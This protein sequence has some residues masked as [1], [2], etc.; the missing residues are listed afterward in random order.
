MSQTTTSDYSEQVN[1]VLRIRDI[2]FGAQMR[3]YEQRFQS[4]QARMQ[5]LQN[6]IDALAAHTDARFQDL[7]ADTQRQ[8]EELR[9]DTRRQF[10]ELQAEMQRRFD[11]LE[12]QLTAHIERLTYE[13]TTRFDLGD[14][15]IELGER[16]K[17]DGG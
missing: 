1:D 4:H 12:A 5:D 17:R 8:F 9:A 2:L 16:L 15:L 14:M 3:D 11:A 10:E 6:Q 13:K 7:R